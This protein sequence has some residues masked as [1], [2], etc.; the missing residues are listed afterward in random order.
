MCD[1]AGMGVDGAHLKKQEAGFKVWP[2]VSSGK[3][4]W[5]HKRLSLLRN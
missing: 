4:I 2:S 3:L 5:G 1:A